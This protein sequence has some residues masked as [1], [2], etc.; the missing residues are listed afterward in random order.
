M[1]KSRKRKIARAKL[2]IATNVNLVTS[3]NIYS[4]SSHEEERLMRLLSTS[5]NLND[6]VALSFRKYADLNRNI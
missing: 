3:T 2:I 4:L 5:G 6:Y 1:I